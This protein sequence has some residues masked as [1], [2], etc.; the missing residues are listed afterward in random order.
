MKYT[1]MQDL[2]FLLWNLTTLLSSRI[3]ST[4]LIPIGAMRTL[5]AGS[6]TPALALYIVYRRDLLWSPANI[7]GV[8][9]DAKI[10]VGRSTTLHNLLFCT[11]TLF[12]SCVTNTFLFVSSSVRSKQLFVFCAGSRAKNRT[13]LMSFSLGPRNRL[14]SKIILNQNLGCDFYMHRV[15]A[16]KFF[17]LI[18]SQQKGKFCTNAYSWHSLCKGN[19]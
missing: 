12:M 9:K 14:F 3:S 16:L 5:E 4:S 15:I 11:H 18:S 19:I 1:Y 13:I 6:R 8:N 10:Y 17:C 7:K 2:L